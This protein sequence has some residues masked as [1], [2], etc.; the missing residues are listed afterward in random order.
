MLAGMDDSKEFHEKKEALIQKHYNPYEIGQRIL[1]GDG[2]SWIR[3]PYDADVIFQ[4]D[5]YHIQQEILRKIKDKKAQQDIRNLLEEG[6]LDEMLE[7]IKLYADS[8]VS[9]D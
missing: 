6:R 8:V 3:D 5:P 9:N 1:N 7:Y 2:G 4:L